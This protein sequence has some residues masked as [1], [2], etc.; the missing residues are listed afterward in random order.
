MSYKFS[1]KL[2]EET[3]ECFKEENGVDITSVEAGMY[4]SS[5]SELFLAFKVETEHSA[6][7]KAVG[8][9]VVKGNNGI[10]GVSNTS[11]TL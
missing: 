5:F 6:P 8:R 2:I 7:N 4:L 3:I 10:R 9:S 11:G 1:Q